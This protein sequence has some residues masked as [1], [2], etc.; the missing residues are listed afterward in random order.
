M[1]TNALDPPLSPVA[2]SF[3]PLATGIADDEPRP[4]EAVSANI[5]NNLLVRS[6]PKDGMIVEQR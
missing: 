5:S 6:G 1:L 2:A 3:K 4:K